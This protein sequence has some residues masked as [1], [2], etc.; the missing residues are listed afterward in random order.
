MA[1]KFKEG[2]KV[3]LKSGGPVMT[4]ESITTKNDDRTGYYCVWFRGAQKETSNFREEVLD[5]A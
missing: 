2:D 1:A 4:V 3:K 5:K